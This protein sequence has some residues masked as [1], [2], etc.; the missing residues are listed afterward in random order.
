M[1]REMQM[2]LARQL[3]QLNREMDEQLLTDLQ[4]QLVSCSNDVTLVCRERVVPS[5][6]QRREAAVFTGYGY[7][8]SCCLDLMTTSNK[9]TLCV[10]HT[11]AFHLET[12]LDPICWQLFCFKALFHFL[13]CIFLFH[14]FRSQTSQALLQLS[15]AS[16]YFFLFS[17]P[18]TNT[19][20]EA[21]WR[22]RENELSLDHSLLWRA[23][24]DEGMRDQ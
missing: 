2:D 13:L 23:T 5:D 4:V 18:T 11:V 9:F 14:W 17:F 3:E 6:G 21:Y 7:R 15:S 22:A 8:F 10:F 24:L 1:E 20:S 16:F 19:A 12:S